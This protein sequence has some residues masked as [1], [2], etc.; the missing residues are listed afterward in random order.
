MFGEMMQRLSTESGLDVLFSSPT[1][2]YGEIEG[3]RYYNSAVLLRADGSEP[4]IYSK[5]HLVPFGEYLPFRK[6]LFFVDK[7]SKGVIGDFA[8][9]EDYTG[10]TL[11]NGHRFGA[12]IC[13]EIL[14][15][16]LIRQF[17][18]K[19]AEFLA[20]IT[21]DTWY[22][23]TTMPYHHFALSVFRAVENRKFVVRVANSGFSGIVAPDGRILKRSQLFSKEIIIY[24]IHPNR[25]KTIYSRFGD[26]FVYMNC[27]IAIFLVF[28]LSRKKQ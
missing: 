9:G 17:S 26:W 25:I 28:I 12:V 10:L 3:R 11:T 4:Q 7:F 6:I 27:A 13:Y 24:S 23:D 20:N 14:F 8:H 16:E 22:G 19:D 5:V 21:N 15:P 2:S 1:S 18:E